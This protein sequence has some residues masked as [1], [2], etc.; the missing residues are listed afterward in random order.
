MASKLCLRC[1]WSGDTRARAC[2]RCGAELFDRP[3]EEPAAA[4]ER[5]WRGWIATGLVIVL[6]AVAFVT[7]QRFTPSAPAKTTGLEG[8]LVYPA[9]DGDHVRLWIWN[10]STDTVQPGPAV[11][12]TPSAIVSLYAVEDSWVGM[13]MPAAH[14]AE[15]QVLRSAD[16]AAQPATLARG[17]TV[18]WQDGGAFVSSTRSARTHGCLHRVIVST[19]SVVDRIGRH[20]SPFLLC[21]NVVGLFRDSLSPYLVT[22]RDHDLQTWRVFSD[23]LSP[24]L[25]GYT[26]LGVS[27]NGDFLVRAPSGRAGMFYPTSTSGPD[28]PSLIALDGDPLLASTLLAW[29]VDGNVAYVLGSIGG[30]EGVFAVTVGPRQQP[31]APVLVVRTSATDVAASITVTNDVYVMAEGTIRYVHDGEVTSVLSPPAGAPQLAGPLLWVLS[32]PYSPSVTP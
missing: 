26:P 30:V 3:G 24:Q 28:K 22:S 9:P 23:A 21:G 31:G 20:T 12:T 17:G 1:D 19:I 29:S 4:P 15:A 13:T 32:L 8:Y 10:L 5:T 2:P 7:I 16:A 27:Q 6:A 25:Q 11:R 14:G 18:A